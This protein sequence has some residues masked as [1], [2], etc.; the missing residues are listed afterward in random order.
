MVK[1]DRGIDRTA[2]GFRLVPS[3]LHP[4][5]RSKLLTGP[6][7]EFDVE[8]PTH[9]ALLFTGTMP[10]WNQK[11]ASEKRYRVWNE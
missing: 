8:Y 7:L 9:K 6:Y 3:G 10:H 1:A 5:S 11:H 4:A 2:S